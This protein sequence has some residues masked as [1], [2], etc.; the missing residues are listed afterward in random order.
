MPFSAVYAALPTP[1]TADGSLAASDIAHNV[2]KY[3]L[4]LF[5]PSRYVFLSLSM[6]YCGYT[7]R[8]EVQFA[9]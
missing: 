5:T 4:L 1:M 3:V 6:F 8:L 2:H 7:G 9:K